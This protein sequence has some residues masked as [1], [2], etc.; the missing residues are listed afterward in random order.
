[1]R[2]FPAPFALLLGLFLSSIASGQSSRPTTR[3]TSRPVAVD[4]KDPAA[5]AA[6]TGSPVIVHG[7]AASAEWST[8]GRVMRIEFVGAE[9]SR[10]YAALFPRDREPFDKKYGGDVAK[11]LDGAEVRITGTLQLYRGRPEIILN[12]VDQLDETKDKDPSPAQAQ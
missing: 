10:F 8:T 2:R 7:T 3:P 5:L 11:A 6:A 9:K 1:M 12:R 4:L